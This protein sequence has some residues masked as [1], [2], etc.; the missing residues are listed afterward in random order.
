M[1]GMIKVGIDGRFL[2]S[3]FTGNG[4]YTEGLASGV[5]RIASDY[6]MDV[7][8]Y[9]PIGVVNHQVSIGQWVRPGRWNRWLGDLPRQLK[10]HGVQIF[11]GQYTLPIG[12]DGKTCLTIHDAA[13]AIPG[14]PEYSR[15][16]KELFTYFARRASV[17]VTVSQSA[18]HD[19]QRIFGN[20][21][22][23]EVVHNGCSIEKATTEARNIVESLIS[24]AAFPVVLYVGRMARRKRIPLLIEGFRQL[25]AQYKDAVLVLAGPEDDDSATVSNE[26]A[27]SGGSILRLLNVSEPLKTALLERAD[28]FAYL[29]SYEGFGLPVA[30]ALLAGVPVVHSDIPS[31]NEVSQG[32][33]IVTKAEVNAVSG[34][35]KRAL[36]V[37]PN[38]GWALAQKYTWDAAAQ[39]YGD[40][41]AT[42]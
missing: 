22:R 15:S 39:R 5:Q 30:E 25:K 10:E 4:R 36:A 23:I 13:F 20:N 38:A 9:A 42:L 37:R 31:L 19:L 6:Q 14:M 40:I 3:P 2:A 21:V 1:T 33:A 16:K 26:V 34:A 17:V 35:L 28:V 12:F 24:E 11:H 8:V 27:R 32:S 7:H 41:Y 29:S 18:K